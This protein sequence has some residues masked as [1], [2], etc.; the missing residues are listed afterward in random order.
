M[1]R[2]LQFGAAVCCAFASAWALAAEFPA[3]PVTIVVPYAPGGLTDHFARSIGNKLS[4][5]WKQTV[6]V[7]NRAGGG[8]VIGT[9]AAA[10]AKPDG[11]TLLLTSYG[12]TSNPILMKSLS[13]DP[14]ALTPLAMVGNAPNMLVLSGRSDLTDLPSVLERA[15]SAPGAL[16][17]ASSGNAS[18]PHI[19]A[20]LFAREVG[21]EVTHVAYRG[22]APAMTDVMGGQVDGIFDGV[23]AMPNVESGKLKAVAIASE[24][25]HAL[26]PDVPTF[27]ELGVDL[28]FGSWFGF[29]VPTGT[30]DAI[31]QQLNAD[32]RTAMEDPEVQAQLTRSGLQLRSGPAR[33]FAAF[34]D[35]ESKR[36]RELAQE[37][38]GITI[39]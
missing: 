1:K 27:R 8:T 36:L 31:Q 29:F 14:K 6:I 24:E 19:A 21:A 22:T 9:Q 26:A 39:D 18:S 4:Q 3:K 15:R 34:L 25:R 28:V 33:E 10:Q 12:Y 17:L 7:D 11:Y 30:P 23:S 5:Q 32:L 16:R 2:F 13:Y 20:A 35:F 38:S 37:G